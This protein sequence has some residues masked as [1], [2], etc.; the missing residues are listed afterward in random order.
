MP[1]QVNL[2]FGF[3]SERFHVVDESLGKGIPAELMKYL[4]GETEKFCDESVFPLVDRSVQDFIVDLRDTIL[5]K[6]NFHLEDASQIWKFQFPVEKQH[7]FET[8]RLE[9]FTPDD[10]ATFERKEAV[11]GIALTARYFP[12]FLDCLC[13]HGGDP[14]KARSSN[15]HYQAMLDEFKEKLI[16]KYPIFQFAIEIYQC[17]FY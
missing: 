3:P 13:P 14:S 9:L 11:F 10:E 1:T 5:N 16:E 4:T 8:L 15:P 2:I 6:Y 7:L 17:Q 12:V